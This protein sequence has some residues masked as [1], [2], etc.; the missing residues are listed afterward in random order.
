MLL[1]TLYML[2]LSSAMVSLLFPFSALC[3][4]LGLS[5]GLFGNN[6]CY[7]YFILFSSFFFSGE[8]WKFENN[9][10]GF[11][12]QFQRRSLKNLLR[13]LVLEN[14]NSNAREERT[15]H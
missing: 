8:I 1:D 12:K 13:L 15:S 6:G 10:I 9:K 3:S 5:L 14:L 2:S 4:L 11:G 7:M